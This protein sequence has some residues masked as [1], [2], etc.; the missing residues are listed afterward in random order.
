MRV[1][2]PFPSLFVS[3]LLVKLSPKFNVPR[4]SVFVNGETRF[5][6]IAVSEVQLMRTD[7][8]TEPILN[9]IRG[10]DR[11]RGKKT[12][13]AI[14]CLN[15]RL[16]TGGRRNNGWQSCCERREIDAV[17][18]KRRGGIVTEVGLRRKRISS[19]IAGDELV[20]D[21]G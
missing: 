7:R 14:Y 10:L 4:V 2:N 12:G 8:P 19:R 13:T 1:A 16:I 20:Y 6:M 9:L 5:W 3:G 15:I 11:M 21:R 17:D 18:A